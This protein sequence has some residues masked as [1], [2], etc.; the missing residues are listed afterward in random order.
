M[1]IPPVQM[2]PRGFTLIEAIVYLALFGIMITGIVSGAFSVIESSGRNQT[3]AML[4]E[5]GN[6]I[7][8]KIHYALASA[9]Q[10]NAP[11][12]SGGTL[13]TTKYDSTSVTLAP[14]GTGVDI[15][16]AVNPTAI[17]F[18]NDDVTVTNLQFVRVAATGDGVNPE[19]VTGS[20]TLSAH[21]PN[22]AMVTQD[23]TTTVYLRR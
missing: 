8:G 15:K 3:H 19:S 16:D 7:I 2:S 13:T 5:E 18:T 12:T 4:Q 20:F 14:N 1:T 10:V 21:A 11:A 17:S 22:G 6:F 23:F 9:S